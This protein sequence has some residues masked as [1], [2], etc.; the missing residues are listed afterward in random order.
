M[1]LFK[2]SVI[3]KYTRQD[4]FNDLKK[5]GG[6]SFHWGVPPTN[7]LQITFQLHHQNSFMVPYYDIIIKVTQ[8][9]Y[10]STQSVKEKVDLT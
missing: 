6:I 10:I 8:I 1:F 5:L 3:I 9:H 7:V 4:K 2:C